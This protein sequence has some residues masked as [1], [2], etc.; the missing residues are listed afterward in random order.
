MK[1]L[2]LD[3][4]DT[5]LDR[6][7]NIPEENQKAIER[8]VDAGHKVGITSGRSLM[9]VLPVVE[10]LGRRKEGGYAIA[11]NGGIIYDC[12][13]K[14]ALIRQTIPL[15]TVKMIFAEADALGIHA[16]TYASDDTLLVRE[17]DEETKFYTSRLYTATRLV[18]DLPDSLSEEPVKCL[19]IDLHDREK[20]EKLRGI[21]AK[22]GEGDIDVF[23][24]NAWYLECVKH[25]VSKGRAVEWFCDHMH[26]PIEDSVSAGDSENDIPMLRAAGVGCA[27]A[28]ATDACKSAADYITERDCDH[29]GVAEIIDRFLMNEP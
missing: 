1:I 7:K 4:D 24:S 10:S 25:G 19:C 15:A 14:K 18:P 17:M 20:I 16:Q 8:A 9:S 12:F 6:E 3:I 29:A 13:A 21:L 2:F 28:N 22:K 26:V 23:F 11:Y 5:L 27:M